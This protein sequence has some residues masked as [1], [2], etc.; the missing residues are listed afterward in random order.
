MS[1]AVVEP[2]RSGSK[3]PLPSK[4]G[5]K[6]SAEV[7]IVGGGVR[8]LSIAHGLA[9]AGVDV[10]LLERRFIAAGA[11]GLSMGYVNVSAKKPSHYTKFSKMSADMYPDFT[12][13]L[14]LAVEYE[15][16]GSLDVAETGEQW[17]SLAEAAAQRNRI[18]DI[19]MRMMRIEEARQLEPE[20]STHLTGGCY[21]PV[22]GGVNPLKL[23]RALA[24]AAVRN[25]VRIRTGCD[26]LDIRT[27]MGRIE[28]VTTNQGAITTQVVVNAAGIHAPEISSMVG[29]ELPVYPERGQLVIT[30]ALPPVLNRAVGPYKQFQDGQV[31]IGVTNEKAGENTRVTTGMLSTITRRALRILPVLRKARA[32]RC[33]AALRPMTPDRLPVYQKIEGVKDFYIAVGHSGFTLAPITAKIFTDLITRGKTDIDLDP[34]RVERFQ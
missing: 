18:P 7:I 21:C 32:I 20:L 16:N 33:A 23:T 26:V 3:T 28:E 17:E 15:R 4:I 13:G 25:G 30:E 12:A 1:S 22:D 2:A 31:L 27:V 8:G 11:S 6:E 24:R 29:V 19:G 14:G 34:Y 9:L 5:K 10:V